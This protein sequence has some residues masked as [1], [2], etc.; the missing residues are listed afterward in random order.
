MVIFILFLKNDMMLMVVLFL[1]PAHT[2][3]RVNKECYC[4]LSSE[5]LQQKAMKLL[6]VHMKDLAEQ[7][8]LDALVS[9]R[10]D[11]KTCIQSQ[12]ILRP[13]AKFRHVKSLRHRIFGLVIYLGFCSDPLPQ[14]R[15][16]WLPER[17][18]R[19]SSL[20]PIEETSFLALCYISHSTSTDAA[21]A[22]PTNWFLQLQVYFRL[23]GGFKSYLATCSTLSQCNNWGKH[24]VW[25]QFAFVI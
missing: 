13:T 20:T 19:H 18:G 8:F 7:I 10:R 3:A 22:C 24:S 23:L 6:L 1:A 16:F 14:C 12:L 4:K 11:L 2:M 15:F 9:Q 21:T 5:L 25:E 17:L